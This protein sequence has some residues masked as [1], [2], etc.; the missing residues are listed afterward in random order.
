MNAWTKIGIVFTLIVLVSAQV[1]SQSGKAAKNEPPEEK[2]FTLTVKTELVVLP[3]TVLDKSG[4]FVTGL[5]EEDFTVYEDGVQQSLEV[6]DDKDIPVALGLMIDNSS[7]MSFRHS[8]VL[9]AALELALNSNPKDEIFVAHFYDR[10]AFNL[11]LSESAFARDLNRLKS[12]V[13]DV[14]KTGRTAL[15]DAVFAGLEHVKQSALTKKVLVV[16]SDGGDNASKH[17]LDEAL[18]MAKA[19]SALIYSIGIFDD[20][21]KQ[22][23]PEILEKLAEISG[24]NVFFP[25][26][27]LDLPEVC[28]RIAVDIRSQ[29]TLGYAP[30]NQNKDGSFRK[31]RV[32][33]R[34]PKQEKL[35]IRTRSG[36]SIAK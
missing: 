3:V 20:R 22:R 36:Y 6:F 11:P 23:K 14:S 12:A 19:S 7:S 27:D 10:V 8:E 35:T 5:K 21:N 13:S 29:Y 26:T 31:I 18:E 33:V 28:K 17:T 16:I 1:L 30:G 15:Y 32:N 4:G 2:P 34:S 24:G 9:E 25:K